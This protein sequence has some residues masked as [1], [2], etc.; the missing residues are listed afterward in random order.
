MNTTISKSFKAEEPVHHVWK[1]LTDPDKLVNCL[2]GASLTETIDDKNYKGEVSIKFGPIKAK[3]D[4]VITFEEID[5]AGKKMKMVGKGVDVKGKG[6]ADMIM[7]CNIS[8]DGGGTQV[9]YTIDIAVTGKIA[10]F[11]SRLITDVSN[12]IFDQFTKN[13]IEQLK[14]EE[15]DNTLSASQMTGT[16]VLSFWDRIIAFFSKLF[17]IS[18]NEQNS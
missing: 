18:S 12:S 1:S 7:N 9:D 3:Y 13:F 11:G 16:V 2:P 14:G 4:G 8:K 6:S 5:E 17:G 10:Q 15:V